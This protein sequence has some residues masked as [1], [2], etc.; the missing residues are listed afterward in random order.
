MIKKIKLQKKNNSNEED[1]ERFK[2]MREF[3][4]CYSEDDTDEERRAKESEW[5]E[6][7]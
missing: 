6:Q 1:Y 3:D 2:D 7:R 5:G 4:E